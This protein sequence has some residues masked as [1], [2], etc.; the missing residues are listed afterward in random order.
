MI[1]S[2]LARIPVRP[3]LLLALASTLIALPACEEPGAKGPTRPLPTY[4]GHAAEVFDD[5]IE[6][7]AAGVSLDVHVDPH[8][9]KGLRERTQVCDAVVRARVTTVTRKPDDNGAHYVV[10]MKTLEKITGNFPPADTFEVIVSDKSPSLGMLKTM[11]G[12][13]VGKTFVAFV[14]AFVRPE[15][16]EE[17]HF[18]LAPD[19][20]DEAAAVREA[21]ALQNL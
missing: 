1:R 8:T 19:T 5:S 14:R 16:E 18:H 9:D 13:I 17:I 21:V 10:G 15:G 11:E 3:A 6:L 2:R 20:K 4:A 7:A 12:A